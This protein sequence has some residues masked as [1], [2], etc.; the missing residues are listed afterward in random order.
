MQ[1][2]NLTVVGEAALEYSMTGNVRG[3]L[4]NR[5]RTFAP[6]GIYPAAGDDRWIAIA[7][8][9]EEQWRALVEAAGH[10]EWASG[11]RFTDNAARKANEDALDAAIAA[12]TASEDRDALADRLAKAGVIAAPVLD[13]LE[14]AEDPV[15]RER[16][17]V[18]EVTH[19]ETGTWPQ[20][21]LPMHFDRTPGSVP[22]S[23]PLQGEHSAEVLER[24]LGITRD[25]HEELVH[26]GVTGS[27]PP[28]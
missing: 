21:G 3:R 5:H 22:R 17:Y 20:I 10:P 15:L 12:W 18:V 16:E 7:A 1:E 11:A 19:P 25:E 26:K 24:F 28:D 9:S 14:L 13:G 6:H 27:G 4:G 2:A 8:E 23:A